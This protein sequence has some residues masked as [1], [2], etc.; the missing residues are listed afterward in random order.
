MAR[1]HHRLNGREFEW[2]PGV[3]D[4]QGGLVCCDS[5]GHKESDTTEW[6]NWTELKASLVAQTVKNLP[7]MQETRV[8]SLG[9]EDLQKKR[10]AT[11]SSVL[12]LRIPWAE[13]PSRLPSTRLQRVRHDW[14]TFTLIPSFGKLQTG[15]FKET[16]LWTCGLE[17]NCSC[18]LNAW[19]IHTNVHSIPCSLIWPTGVN[20]LI[21][22]HHP[23]SNH[24]CWDLQKFIQQRN[25]LQFRSWMYHRFLC[26][27]KTRTDEKTIYQ[28]YFF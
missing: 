28:R 17:T 26:T 19:I 20:L 15:R 24:Y 2:T 7:V 5:W 9:Q 25:F 23:D 22:L 6:L 12:A 11:H 27:L 8:L 18:L 14:G 1:W 16:V 13:E 21:G 3:G 4:G 10:M